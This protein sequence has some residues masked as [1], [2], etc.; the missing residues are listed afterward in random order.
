MN[1]PSFYEQL[2]TNDNLGRVGSTKS[3]DSIV[4]LY[5]AFTGDTVDR[6]IVDSVVKKTVVKAKKPEKK[7]ERKGSSSIKASKLSKGSKNPAKKIKQK[8]SE[9]GSLDS[10]KADIKPSMYGMCVIDF[11]PLFYGKHSLIKVYK[12]KV[13]KRILGKSSYTE[14]LMI[15]PMEILNDEHMTTHKIC[16]KI[17]VSVSIDKEICFFNPVIL[18][19]TLESI[20]NIPSIMKP[21]MDYKICAMLPMENSVS[22]RNAT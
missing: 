15:N 1:D 19:V 6:D 20:Y 5:E 22:L 2:Q 7:K 13:R 3:F 17:T 21:E 10:L 8:K 12:A 16:P 18:N 11:L 4:S 14:T 9:V